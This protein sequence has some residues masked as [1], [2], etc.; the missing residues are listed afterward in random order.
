MIFQIVY[1]KA[2]YFGPD[3]SIFLDLVE[4]SIDN[5]HKMSVY[6]KKN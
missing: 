1:H 2:A 6:M 3:Y 5:H 4:H